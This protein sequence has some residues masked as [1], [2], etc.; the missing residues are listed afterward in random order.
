MSR[1]SARLVDPRAGEGA[2]LRPVTTEPRPAD[3]RAAEA[4]VLPLVGLV[5]VRVEALDEAERTASLRV[6]RDLVEA[7]LDASVDLAVARTALARGERVI[8]QRESEGWVVLGALRTAA[9][10]GV[11]EG[12]DFVIKAKRVAVRSEHEL[13]LVS[14]AASVVIRAFGQVETLAESITA[15]A[16]SVHKIIGR[17]IRLN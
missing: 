7:R 11:D 8:A 9:T 17:V 14:G 16:S 12:E 3:T 10:P 6:G 5:A 1:S 4:L 15:R 2:A 13:S